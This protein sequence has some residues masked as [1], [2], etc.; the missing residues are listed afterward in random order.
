MIGEWQPLG[1]IDHAVVGRITVSPGYAR[2]RTIFAT[3]PAGLHVSRDGGES[4]DSIAP[5]ALSPFIADIAL[6]PAFERDRRLVTTSP[7]GLFRSADA[8]E[9]WEFVAEGGAD[10]HLAFVDDGRF[11]AV[12]PETGATWVGSFDESELRTAD[13]LP[14]E[15]RSLS[16][17]PVARTSAGA[18]HFDSAALVWTP[19]PEIGNDPPIDGLTTTTPDDSR[20]FAGCEPSGVGYSDDGGATWRTATIPHA[21][22]VTRIE[23][24]G[25]IVATTVDGHRFRHSPSTNAWSPV[26]DRANDEADLSTT[27][28]CLSVRGFDRMIET[29]TDG[30]TTRA[31]LDPPLPVGERIVDLACARN[32]ASDEPALAVGVSD[33]SG[34]CSVWL[35][36]GAEPWRRVIAHPEPSLP[37]SLVLLGGPRGLFAAIGEHVYRP[38]RVGSA[39]YVSEAIDADRRCQAL[40]LHGATC[41]DGSVHLALLTSNGLYLSGDGGWSWSWRAGPGDRPLTAIALRPGAVA[42]LVGAVLGGSIFAADLLTD[43]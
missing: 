2:D 34:R 15:M 33:P 29:T 13:V 26:R 3:T 23:L 43:R 4:W 7:A 9:T 31:R 30:G 28:G 11:V 25:G 35:R 38:A 21:A 36:A 8:G 5:G 32:P 20:R 39:L 6:S 1:R 17:G 12:C 10:A 40:R 18:C 37:V 14:G 42:R 22:V 19:S 16:P 27:D 24:R 41:D